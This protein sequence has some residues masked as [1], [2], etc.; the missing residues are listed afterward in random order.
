MARMSIDDSFFRD[1]RVLHLAEACG[2]SLR[3]TRGCLLEVWALCYDRASEDLPER[4]VDTTAGLVGFAAMLLAVDLATRKTIRGRQLMRIHGAEERIRYLKTRESAGRKG[5]LKS[6]ETRR[7]RSKLSFNQ[8][9]EKIEA[10]LNPPD[11]VPDAS[12]DLVPDPDL[13]HALSPARARGSGSSPLF[14]PGSRRELGRLAEL[15]YERVSEARGVVAAELGM[16]A[17]P[18]FPKITPSTRPRGYRDLLD[19]ITE[20]GEAA[21]KVCDLV[22]SSLVAQARDER[23]LEWLSEKAFTEGGWRTARNYLGSETRRAPRSRPNGSAI[24]PAAPHAHYP[25]SLEPKP[26]KDM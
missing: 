20:E 19:R 8:T 6:A 3:E 12:P 5:G 4:D 22:V 21:P 23:K 7:N 1:P 9:F 2:W 14:D 18:P 26:I 15:T 25:T 11:P 17:P 16:L 13:T 10:P 24:G